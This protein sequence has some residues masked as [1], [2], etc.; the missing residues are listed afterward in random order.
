MRTEQEIIEM[1]K[2]AVFEVDNKK[3]DNLSHE[4]EL[5][6]LGLDSVQ[7]MEVIGTM[8]EKLNLQFP[9]EDLATLRSIGDLTRLVKKLAH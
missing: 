3:L 5:S 4:T 2:A 8:E 7:T 1:F 6:A 9:D